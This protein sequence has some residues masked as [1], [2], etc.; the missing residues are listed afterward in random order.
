MVPSAELPPGFL[1]ACSNV[2]N[3]SSPC[4]TVGL[5]VNVG[6]RWRLVR[7]IR[8]SLLF[9]AILAAAT[10]V[11]TQNFGRPLARPIRVEP[12]D[13]PDLVGRVGPYGGI[14]TP[15]D[16]RRMLADGL[17]L[18]VL[19]GTSS[20]VLKTL[21]DAGAKR[22]DTRL[23]SLLLEVCRRQYDIETAARQPL[24]CVVSTMDQDLIATQA[25]TYLR[26]V[27]RDPALVGYWTLDD[28]PHGDVTATLQRFRDLVQQ[29]NTRSGFERPTLCG[30]GGQLDF[31]RST[32]DRSFS[33]DRR[34]TDQAL[35]N[36]SPAGCD[37]VAP[38]FY[39]IASTDDARLIDWSMRELLPYFLRALRARGYDRPS[40]VMLPIAHAFSSHAAGSASYYVTPNPDDVA[41]QMQAYCESGAMSILFFTWQSADAD[42]SYVNDATL[43]EGVQKGRASCTQVW[44][45][46]SPV[47]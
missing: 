30:V 18:A 12:R 46:R 44:R 21:E 33:L 36:V 31:K 32:D 20:D 43:R 25:S 6:T 11:A 45:T 14:K 28:Y 9:I 42:R 37:L 19:S 13:W 29:S 2:L 7:V 22:I 3:P 8:C 4:S 16:A 17:R 38:Y 23:W 27:E 10:R 39:G 26:Q 34:Y 1:S 5:V 47:P 24:A 15:D 41:T 40:Q 35:Q